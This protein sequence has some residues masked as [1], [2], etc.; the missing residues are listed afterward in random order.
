VTDQHEAPVLHT[1][2]IWHLDTEAA[3]AVID[4][5]HVY[6]PE[7]SFPCADCGNPGH[8]PGFVGLFAAETDDEDDIT[9]RVNI[10]L[11]AAEAILLADRLTR[12][13]HLVLESQEDAPDVEREAARF[14]R[15]VPDAEPE[16]PGQPEA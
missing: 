12:A 15:M 3:D 11:T 4:V 7:G 6:L 2:S 10:L 5:D 16:G 8:D 1:R 13:A 14:T 9:A